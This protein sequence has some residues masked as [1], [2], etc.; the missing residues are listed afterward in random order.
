MK[1]NFYTITPELKIKKLDKSIDKKM[2]QTSNQITLAKSLNYGYYL[3]T[4]ILLGVFFGISLDK[5]FRKDF[6]ILIFLI[7]GILGSFYNL[8]KIVKET[9]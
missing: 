7:I 6:F 9:K 8:W 1:K 2:K 5:F 3:I 4:P